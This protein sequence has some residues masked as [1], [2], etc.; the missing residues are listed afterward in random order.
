MTKCILQKK[1]E[2][3]RG[4]WLN[5]T[6]AWMKM[7]FT[8]IVF[9]VCIPYKVV[10]NGCQFERPKFHHHPK[11][12]G[13]VDRLY[14]SYGKVINRNLDRYIFGRILCIAI[15][16]ESHIIQTIDSAHDLDVLTNVRNQYCTIRRIVTIFSSFPHYSRSNC[17]C[18]FML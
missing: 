8:P 14:A 5:I 7:K 18:V 2:T 15:K 13:K 3:E 12:W 4:L 17:V 11:F 9:A 16:I 10:I 6:S 1:R